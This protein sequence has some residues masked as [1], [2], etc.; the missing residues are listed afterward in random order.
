[1]HPRA[2]YAVV[3]K[4]WISR[5]FPT[6]GTRYA[7]SMDA[8]L[9]GDVLIVAGILMLCCALALPIAATLRARQDAGQ[10]PP[11]S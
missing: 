1:V 5:W 9:I 2:G 6:P 7:G 8:N 10:L 3:V 11:G 4:I